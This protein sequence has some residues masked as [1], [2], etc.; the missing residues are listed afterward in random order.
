MPGHAV[1]A[2]EDGTVFS[3][4]HPAGNL[5]MAAA[6]RFALRAGG[7]AAAKNADVVCGD[8]GVLPADVV[9]RLLASGEVTFPMVFPKAGT[10]RVWVQA[11]IEGQIRTGFFR[12]DVPEG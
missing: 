1:V 12:V 10:Y 2:S 5:S 7:D 3:H 6:R 4:L 9:R 11:R 8:L